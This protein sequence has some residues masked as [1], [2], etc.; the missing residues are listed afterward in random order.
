VRE[1]WGTVDDEGATSFSGVLN[2]I[3]ESPIDRY[4]YIDPSIVPTGR[5]SS[6]A[7]I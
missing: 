7:L 2:K 3:A 6:C 4:V 5:E 1:E